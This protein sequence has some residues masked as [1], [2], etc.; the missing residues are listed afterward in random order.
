MRVA[1]RPGEARFALTRNRAIFE[2]GAG[3][4][5]EG[6]GE[7]EPLVLTRVKSRVVCRE[8]HWVRRGL[9][10]FQAHHIGGRA[11]NTK[12]VLIGANL[13]A[14]LTLLQDCFWRG[15]HA[16]GSAYAIGFDLAAYS[17]YRPEAVEGRK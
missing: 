15:H 3:A 1:D 4:E 8:C 11:P 6:C 16:Q 13:H 7:T 17:T 12:T 9:S 5:C 2:L 14:V 10:P